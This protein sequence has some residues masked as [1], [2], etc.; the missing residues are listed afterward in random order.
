MMSDGPNPTTILFF[1]TALEHRTFRK[2]VKM[3]SEVGVRARY[4]GFTRYNYPC[5]ED[6]LETV[7]LGQVK[8]GNYANRFFFALSRLV[9]V[10]REA[11][12]NDLMYCFAL[13]SLVLAHLATVGMRIPIAYQVQDIRPILVGSKIKNRLS[14]FLEKLALGR[15]KH[16]VLSSYAY[17]QNHFK[18]HYD[19]SEQ[20][21]SVIENKLENDP[22]PVASPGTKISLRNPTPIRI[23]YF[24]MLRCSRSWEILKSAVDRAEG[25]LE[26]IVRGKPVGLETFDTDVSSSNRIFYG[27]SYRSPDELADLY[28]A[29]DLVWTAYPYGMAKAGNWQWAR[30]VR[31]YE[32]GAFGK[33]MISQVETQDA[34]VISQYGI[35]MNIDMAHPQVAI[36]RLL[37]ISHGELSEWSRNLLNTPRAL[38]IH[39][40]E[41]YRELKEKLDILVGG[42]N[43][44]A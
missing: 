33:P 31:F 13:D 4:V 2:T 18:I 19:L 21:I 44:L 36:K 37:S 3:L 43:E 7:I 1:T 22:D 39:T 17:Y 29:V 26:L 12:K 24:G 38:F 5:A 15:V 6:G 34:Y 23:G 32:A 25:R 11:K 8:Q 10:R 35:G 42:A 20:S 9:L 41:E 40:E 14:R 16:V 28:E 30:T 27:G